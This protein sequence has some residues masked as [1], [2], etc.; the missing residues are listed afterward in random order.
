MC[1][2]PSFKVETVPNGEFGVDVTVIIVSYNTRDLTLACLDSV[3]EQTTG[4]SFQVLVVDNHSHDESPEAI[5]DSF[6]SVDLIS[7]ENNI[8]FGAANNLAAKRATGRFLLLLNP[9][10][11]IL[12]GAIQRIVSFAD[13][14]PDYGIYGGRTLFEDGTLNPT[15]CWG[16]PTPWGL[17]CMSTGLSVIFP[18]S[19]VFDRET[20][21]GWARDTVREVDIVTGCFL[22]I[23][24]PLWD[25]LCGFDPEFFMYGED[26]DLCLRAN[27]LGHRSVICPQACLIHHGGRSESV[28]ADKLVK[29]L[30]AKR[31]LY[32]RHWTGPWPRAAVWMQATWVLARLAAWTLLGVFRTPHSLAKADT[33]RTVWSRRAEWMV[34]GTK[35]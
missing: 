28:P 29:L 33:L 17:F 27:Q 26:A 30:D 20:Y 21:G 1:C 24:K 16:R 11:V 35:D 5:H 18:G 22:L 8:G 13:Q 6:P 9:D 25:D 7:L 23:R 12:D 10:T 14:N 31:R 3:L 4:V 15:S 2:T 19:R 32:R 34:N